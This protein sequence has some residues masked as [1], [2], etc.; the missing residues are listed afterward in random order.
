MRQ[1]DPI[2]T[3]EKIIRA[4]EAE[5]SS[6]G[7]AGARMQGIAARAGVKKELLYHYF[8]G[9]EQ[10]FAEVRD[11]RIEAG[12]RRE[13]V[14]PEDAADLF[15]VRFERVKADMEW[16]R[17]ITWEAAQGHE[18]DLPREEERRKTIRRYVAALKGE[19][20][21]GRLPGDIDPRYLQLAVFALTT[22]PL[23]FGQITRL[24]TGR[25]PCDAEF[26]KQWSAFLRKLGSCV[27]DASGVRTRAKP[28]RGR[29]SS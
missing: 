22:Y 29:K 14:S 27:A 6:K 26:Q 28:H 21:R 2:R 5:F 19:Q 12:M 9:K 3:R 15:A 20:A 16:V 24:T 25:S 8:N 10:L 23:A 1:R 17:L 13:P 4:A 7:Y 11:S 18:E